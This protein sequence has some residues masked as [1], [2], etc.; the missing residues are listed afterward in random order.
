MEGKVDV[1]DW[2]VEQN[3][4]FSS[5]DIFDTAGS[6]ILGNCKEEI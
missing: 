1:E 5:A 3:A 2:R 4:F 6:K